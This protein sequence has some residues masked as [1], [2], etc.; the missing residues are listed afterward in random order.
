MQKDNIIL[1]GMMGSG[2]TSVGL[3]I[4]RHY[5]FNF[6]DLDGQIE[7]KFGKI[8]DIFKNSGENHFRELETEELKSLIGVEKTILSTGGGTPLK[9]ENQEILNKIGKVFYLSTSAGT[10][11]ER[12]KNQ[13]HRPLLATC[14][15]KKTI[16]EILSKRIGIYEKIGEKIITDNKIPK[17]IAEEIYEKFNS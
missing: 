10:I 7:K 17:Q 3:E 2:K 6:I 1:I 8:S 11:Y 15:P 4:S 16:E 5:G 13:N 12:I 14:D 9:E